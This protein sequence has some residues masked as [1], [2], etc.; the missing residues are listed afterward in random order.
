MKGLPSS[1]AGFLIGLVPPFGFRACPEVLRLWLVLPRFFCGPSAS[2]WFPSETSTSPWPPFLLPGIL[3]W[4]RTS[5]RKVNDAQKE[6]GFQWMLKAD[7]P[8]IAFFALSQLPVISY[9][10]LGTFGPDRRRNVGCKGGLWSEIN[11]LR[12]N[13]LLYN[14]SQKGVVSL[15]TTSLGIAGSLG[16]ELC[17][18]FD[19]QKQSPEG[20]SWCYTLFLD[21]CLDVPAS[22]LRFCM[23]R[24]EEP[25]L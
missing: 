8:I 23:H 6:K 2:I 4:S 16:I 12:P 18:C 9:N 3:Q 21:K 15:M 10:M 5:Q 19:N 22:F 20:A 13:V 25:C 14:H 1:F 17:L 11:R 24:L 7:I